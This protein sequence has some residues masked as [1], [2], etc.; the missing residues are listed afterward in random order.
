MTNC[1]K[2]IEILHR[3]HDGDDLAPEHRRL[4]E[5]AI[6]DMVSEAG[7]IQAW[8]YNELVSAVTAN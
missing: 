7:Q 1:E 6:N 3:T 8:W 2:A 4:L 5:L